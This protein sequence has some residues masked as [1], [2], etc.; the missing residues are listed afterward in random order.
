MTDT[1]PKISFII[2]VLHLKRPLNKARFFMPRYTLPDVLRDLHDNVS[3]PHEVIVVCNGQDRELVDY[4]TAH[5]HIDKYCLNSVNVG[6]ARSWN[7]GAAMAEG[8][9]LCYL[10]DDV[11]V[12]KHSIE[13]LFTLFHDTL[14]GEVGPAGSYWENLQHHSYVEG[15]QPVESDAVSGF[16]FLVRAATFRQLG[17]FDV[18]YSPAGYEEIDFSF[19]IRQAGLKCVVHPGVNIKHFHHHGVSA[20][21]VDIFYLNKT[22]D[23]VALN[24]KN[25]A[26]FRRKWAE[27]FS[28]IRNACRND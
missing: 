3:L 26:Y 5:P 19:R 12:G 2:P 9:I 20:Q 27:G 28:S 7:M 6:V 1:L 22:I 23:T 10:N 11:S 17:G 16:C 24:M 25:T 14:V 13:H 18:E 21:K 8:D 4:V 15:E